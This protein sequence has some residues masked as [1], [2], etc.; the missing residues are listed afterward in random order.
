MAAVIDNTESN[1]YALP[2]RKKPKVSELPLSS[3]KRASIDGLLHTF[4]K[5]GEFD[6]L[7]KK[8]W[9]QF[10]ESTQANLIQ[11]LQTFTDAEIERDP[12]KYLAKDRRLAAP[13]LEGAAARAD[14]Y[15]ATEA[16]IDRYITQYLKDAETALRDIRR[17]EIGEDAA[18]EEE[19]NGARSDEA[20]AADA[21]VRRQKRAKLY[22]EQLK[23]QKKK[24]KEA[25][26]K[27]ELEA[28]KAREAELLKEKERL[29]RDAKRRQDKEIIRKKEEERKKERLKQMEEEREKKRKEREAEEKKLEEER[30]LRKKKEEEEE[31]KRLEAEAE[32]MLLRESQ[33]M[34]EKTSRRERE[35]TED[36]APPS[37]RE[38]VPDKRVSSVRDPKDSR[39]EY[40]TR[41]PTPERERYA[42]RRDDRPRQSYYDDREGRSSRHEREDRHSR[43]EKEDRQ[44]RQERENARRESHLREIS[45][46]RKAWLAAK[47]KESEQK[48]DAPPSVRESASVRARSKSP[49]HAGASR[50][51]RSPRS[52]KYRDARPRSRTRSPPRR[53]GAYREREYSPPRRRRSRSRSPLDID[54]YIPTSSRTRDEDRDRYATRER[55]DDRYAM[56]DRERERDRDRERG[57]EYNRERDRDYDRERDRDYDRDRRR[58]RD[59]EPSNKEIDRYIPSNSRLAERGETS[60]GPSARE[61]SIRRERSTSR[62]REHHSGSKPPLPPPT[63]KP[64][65]PASLPVPELPQGKLQ[66]ANLKW[67]PAN[68]K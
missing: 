9:A 55:E 64:P 65:K 41:S 13:L 59:E 6:A 24:E 8:T 30:A 42:S 49:S 16:D 3:A 28:L 20:Y 60:I 27:A 36:P 5:K 39:K 32:R 52:E 56:R 66:F 48:R 62:G 67:K 34:M 17:K 25:K 58:P 68:A 45:I 38:Y 46:E 35:H 54:R 43:Y 31:H 11:S 29:E 21:E 40:R 19:A 33:R 44:S 57:R 51:D 47:R 61:P 23:I 18:R 26:K 4:K 10:E 63:L 2:P 7:R 37:H 1:D 12:A 14:I 53:S 22:I 15:P 50:H